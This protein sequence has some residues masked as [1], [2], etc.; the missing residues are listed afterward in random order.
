MHS[1]LDPAFHKLRTCRAGV[2]ASQSRSYLASQACDTC[3]RSAT[4]RLPDDL[5]QRQAAE[6][7]A[8]RLERALR[9]EEQRMQQAVQQALEQ[10][11]EQGREEGREQGREEAEAGDSSL[12]KA[13][14]GADSNSSDD[15]SGDG[16]GSG[17][18]ARGGSG[19]AGGKAACCREQPAVCRKATQQGQT[20]PSPQQHHAQG[21]RQRCQQQPS[22]V[23]DDVA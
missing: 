11:R 12:L 7:D 3:A 6:R 13:T 23:A 2:L 8:R 21:W 4:S 15:S 17:A 16:S 18:G 5:T 14:A 9:S 19:A 22:A 1:D 10:G 20:Q